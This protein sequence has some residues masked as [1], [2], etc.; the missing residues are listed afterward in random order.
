MK[1]IFIDICKESDAPIFGVEEKISVFNPEDGRSM[2]L[3]NVG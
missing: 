2:V 3:L 1:L